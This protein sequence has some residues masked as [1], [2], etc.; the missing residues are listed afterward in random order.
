M[1]PEILLHSVNMDIL[2]YIDIYTI[3]HIYVNVL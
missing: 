2:I 3:Y 1:G